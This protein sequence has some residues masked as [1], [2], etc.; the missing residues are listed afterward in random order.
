MGFAKL[1]CGLMLIPTLT[2]PSPVMNAHHQS[3]VVKGEASSPE[4]DA[5]HVAHAIRTILAR[6]EGRLSAPALCSQL[7]KEC[8]NAKDIIAK[9][10]GIKTFIT[11]FASQDV[12][13]VPGQVRSLCPHARRHRY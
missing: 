7:Y 5:S 13:F 1:I 10:K 4:S 12:E 2:N 9:H 11:K 8:D 3:V 6:R